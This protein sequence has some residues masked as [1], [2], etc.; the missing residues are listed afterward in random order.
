MENLSV[1][2][3]M[4][5]YSQFNQTVSTMDYLSAVMQGN[6]VLPPAIVV[7][8]IHPN[9]NYDLTPIKGELANDPAT[10]E[11]TGGGPQFL[12]FLTTEVIPYID[13]KYNTCKDRTIIGHSLGGL[14]IFQA[15]LEKREFFVNYLCIDPGLGFADR[16]FYREVMDTL[17]SA[18]LSDEHFF[19]AAA[20]NMPTFMAP[21]ELSQDTTFFLEL[22]DKPNME[23]YKN[24]QSNNWKIELDKKYYKDENHYSVPFRATYDAFRQFYSFY[25]FQEMDHYFHASYSDK[26]DLLPRLKK[27]Y[28]VISENI[29]CTINPLEDYLNVWA[30]GL[31]T[32]E[33]Y[34]IA[35]DLFKYNIELYPDRPSVHNNYGYHLHG[36]GKNKEALEQFEKSLDLERDR[37]IL[38][39]KN[40]ILEEMVE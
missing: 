9:R 37:E 36:I 33:R 4:D 18:D 34:V 25:Q 32:G 6:D 14:L 39:I 2:Y 17:E 27:H 3:V 10:I 29:G 12:E 7:G 20:N 23:F 26:M 40:A 31:S 16:A 19:F 1:V 8:M 28:E 24:E 22:C 30:W 11:T 5:G 15:L 13:G 21:E 35:A 38:D